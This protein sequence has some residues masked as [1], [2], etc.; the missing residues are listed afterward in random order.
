MQT[1]VNPYRD[2]S[3]KDL[4]GLI[5]VSEDHLDH[6]FL[7]E[8]KRRREAF[9]PLLV[10]VLEKEEHYTYDDPRFW[11]VIHAVHLAGVLGDGLLLDALLAAGRYADQHDIEWI[12]DILPECYLRLGVG[13]IPVLG[14]YVLERKNLSSFSVASEVLGLWNIWNAYPQTRRSIED[15]LLSVITAPE[16]SLEIRTNLMADF[17]KI[18]RSDLKPMFDDLY[19]RGE[20]DLNLFTR[21]DIEAFFN[22]GK[23]PTF[24][25]SRLEEFYSS[26]EIARRQ[27]IWQAEAERRKQEALEEYIREHYKSIAGDAPCPCGS[28]RPFRQ[29]HLAW[30]E[31]AQCS[32]RGKSTTINEGV[33]QALPVVAEHFYENELRRF[34]AKKSK[35]ILF[36]E[37]KQ[38][39]QDLINAPVDD[40]LSGNFVSFFE[41][42][43]TKIGFEDTGDYKHF[44]KSFMEYFN[45]LSRQR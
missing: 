11:G 41:P 39:V 15:L 18:G 10:P 34:L 27:A 22:N 17:A 33:M 35:T 28:G 24:R 45:A 16:T 40:F 30:A 36:A 8:V 38:R 5:F 13:V 20:T 43:F 37:I 26:E 14:R 21:D 25:H 42:V 23:N 32:L 7:E 2:L 44:M 4:I 12:L 29:C 9:V 19:E 3:D 31:A 6:A 1:P